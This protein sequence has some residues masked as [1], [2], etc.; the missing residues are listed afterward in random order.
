MEPTKK[1]ISDFTDLLAWQEGHMLVLDV[2]KI[3]RM[4]PKEEL[5][6][7][8][9]QIRRAVV[10]VTSN[11]AEGFGRNSYKER[12]QFYHLA[13]GSLIEVKNQL[14]VARDVGYIDSSMYCKAHTQANQAHKVLQGLITKT[15]SF[16][17]SKS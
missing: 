11:I 14:L 13:Q 12:V 1:T 3:T 4:F 10:S 5:F 17:V 15:K 8:T 6:A 2:Y 7:L 9:S 16:V